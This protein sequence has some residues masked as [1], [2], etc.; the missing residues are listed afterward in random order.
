ML[1]TLLFFL[2]L[3]GNNPDSN[4]NSDYT[5]QILN[6]TEQIEVSSPAVDTA[7]V[8]YKL[9]TAAK[10]YLGV[11]YTWGGYKEKININ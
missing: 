3:N 11:P 9:L 2:V 10:K 8:G 4:C 7:S 1:K 5:N 6:E